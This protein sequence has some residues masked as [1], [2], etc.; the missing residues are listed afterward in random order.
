MKELNALTATQLK[1]YRQSAK[2]TAQTIYQRNFKSAADGQLLGDVSTSY[3]MLPTHPG[4]P[5]LALDLCGKQLKI[6]YVVRDPIQRIISH[7][8]YMA[9]YVGEGRMGDDINVAV[10]KHPELLDYSRYAMQIKPWIDTFGLKNIYIMRFE[11]Y[12]DQRAA[13]VQR[14]CDFLGVEKL[15]LRDRPRGCQSDRRSSVHQ[16]L[17]VTVLEYRFISKCDPSLDAWFCRQR[18]AKI[19]AS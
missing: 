12:V 1:T 11:E 16:S 19:V 17:A 6:I 13:A 5:E 7:H 15:Q 2:E 10:S 14:L 18:W 8:R 9:S 4:I 3:S